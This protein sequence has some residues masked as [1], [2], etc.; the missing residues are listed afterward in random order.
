[1]S[2]WLIV[3]SLVALAACKGSLAD[4]EKNARAALDARDWT[5][6]RNISEQ[7]LVG[8]TSGDDA[9]MAWRLEQIRLDALANDKQGQEVIVTLA[10][11]GANQSY[12]PQ[13]TPALYRSLADKL[14]TAGDVDGAIDVLVAGDKKFPQEH[15][16]FV[17]DIEGLKK[18]NLDPAQVE[19]LKSLGYL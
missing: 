11:L 6:A 8:V 2:R 14:K 1:M 7:A 19:R 4:H 9:A 18:G 13:I 10:R 16:Q 17:K 3:L 15:E 12:A 5:G